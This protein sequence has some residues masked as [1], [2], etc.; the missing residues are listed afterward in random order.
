MEI[1]FLTPGD[2]DA[3]WRVRLE[4]L[5]RSP[6]AFS[7]S[8][9]E[10]RALGMDEVRRRLGDGD[11]FVAGAVEEGRIVGTAGFYRDKGPKL[12]HKGRVW[13]VYVSEDR[14]G[15][16]LGRQMLQKVLERASALAGL[17]QVLLSVATT[18]TAAIRLYRSLGFESFGCEPRALKVGDRTIDEEY[19][20]FRINRPDSL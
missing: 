9:E 14:R 6:E 18:Q 20:I 4:A 1:R 5:E 13:G 8:V 11:L 7:S 10:H 2:S 3:Y 17:E 16:G 12:R 15:L 19:M